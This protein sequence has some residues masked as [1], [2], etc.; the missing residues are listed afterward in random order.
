QATASAAQLGRQRDKAA[1]M[2]EQLRQRHAQSQRDSAELVRK[3]AARNDLA[4]ERKEKWRMLEGLQD[5][6]EEQKGALEK[7]ERDLRFAMPRNVSTGL[8]AVER[9]VKE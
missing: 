8:D 1:E 5:R 3:T 7:S 4:E 2:E 9:L 6:I